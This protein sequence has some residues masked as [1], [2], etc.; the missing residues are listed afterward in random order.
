MNV[1]ISWSG[2]ESKHIAVALKEWLPLVIQAIDPYVSCED[3]DKGARWSADIARELADTDFGILCLTRTNQHSPWINFE[4]GALAKAVDKARVCP[5][6]LD[7][8]PADL[9]GD[10][11][12]PQ[13][14]AV[15]FEKDD[16]LKMLLALNKAQDEQALPDARLRKLFD[17]MWPDLEGQLQSVVKGLKESS[18]S[19]S[20]SSSN[21]EDT[22]PVENMLAEILSLVRNLE[23]QSGASLGPYWQRRAQSILRRAPWKEALQGAEAC[24][25]LQE[26]AEQLGVNLGNMVCDST[27]SQILLGPPSASLTAEQRIAI[28][29]AGRKMGYEVCWPIPNTPPS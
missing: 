26:L 10:G 12:L 20:S 11:P 15:T 28:N 14:Q 4:A 1:F 3:I 23:R 7:M 6:L 22:D 17:R 5:F 2:E 19:S 13:F 21:R 24:R 16:V 27:A 9:D 29:Q 25:R 8:R 18:S